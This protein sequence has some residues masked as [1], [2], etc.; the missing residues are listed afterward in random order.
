MDDGILIV[1]S[2]E[3]AM[4]LLEDL[5]KFFKEKL[6]LELNKKTTYMPVSKGCVFCGYR[7]FLDYRL[8]KRANVNRM[9]KRIKNW[10]YLW[11]KNKYDFEKWRQSFSAWKGYAK[12]ANSY[13]L[14]QR[15]EKKQKFLIEDENRY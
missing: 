4:E 11:S 3:K 1:E 2:K 5:K 12:H 10:N 13:R 15:L 8:V 7:V 9:K 14:I 6:K